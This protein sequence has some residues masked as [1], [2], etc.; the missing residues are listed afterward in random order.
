MSNLISGHMRHVPKK[1]GGGVISLQL[2]FRYHGLNLLERAK[3][4]L[5]DKR[6]L[7]TVRSAVCFKNAISKSPQSRLV[8][9]DVNFAH[10]ICMAGHID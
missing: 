7:P 8:R 3:A 9:Q 2:A 4:I 6:T 5:L 1:F 10:E